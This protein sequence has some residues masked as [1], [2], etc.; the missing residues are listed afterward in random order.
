[1]VLGQVCIALGVMYKCQSHDVGLL[2]KSS[3]LFLVFKGAYCD[4][5]ETDFETPFMIAL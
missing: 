3:T 4:V 5:S 2:I 1:M